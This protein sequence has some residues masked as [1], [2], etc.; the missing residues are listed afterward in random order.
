MLSDNVKRY[1]TRYTNS[2]FWRLFPES[3]AF[4]FDLVV[5]IVWQIQKQIGK[6]SYFFNDN[7]IREL[8][9]GTA[10]VWSYSPC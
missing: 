4:F 9:V 7:V 2:T 6:F 3:K 8:F 5:M 1:D 10:F